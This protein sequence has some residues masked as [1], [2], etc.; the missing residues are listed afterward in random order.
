MPTQG[1]PPD[2]V[3]IRV[4]HNTPYEGAEAGVV[5]PCSLQQQ[6][7]AGGMGTPGIM[8]RGARDR[9]HCGGGRGEGRRQHSVPQRQAGAH[10]APLVLRR[11][12]VLRGA[13]AAYLSC[14]TLS[15]R[16]QLP[17]CASLW[18]MCYFA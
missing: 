11:C 2:A 16:A 6:Q 4:L 9:L 12:G 5:G 1:S 15:A 8:P 17:M 10:L 18:L 7:H 3:L 14:V 13:T